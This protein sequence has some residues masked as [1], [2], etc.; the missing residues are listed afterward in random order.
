MKCPKCGIE[1]NI[2]DSRLRFE[3]DNSPDTPT[4][5]IRVLTLK[6]RNPQCTGYTE[7]IESPEE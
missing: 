4:K 7:T 3:G 1:M 5:A 2:A 6:C